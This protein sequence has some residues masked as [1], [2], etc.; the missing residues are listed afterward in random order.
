MYDV[1][2]IG[3]GIVGL[4]TARETLLR[5]PSLTLAVLEKEN[6]IGQHQ[7]GHNSG[8]I[9]SGL[10][11]APGS[12]KAKTCVAGRRALIHYCDAKGIPYD[13]CGKLV[14]ATT[15]KELAGLHM[16]YERGTANGVQDLSLLEPDQFRDIE[17]HVRG[18]RGLYS[19]HTGI[20]DYGQV[21]RAY[22]HDV[23]E[24]GGAILTGHGVE[25][26][27]RRKDGIT[28]ITTAGEIHTRYLVACAGLYA[29]RVARMSI[30][31]RDPQIVPFRGDYYI[32]KPQK[33]HLV[34][35]LI[36][37]VPDPTLP[38]LGVHLTRRM[39]GTVWLGPNAVLAFAREGYR[40]STLSGLDMADTVA[41]PAF[42]KFLRRYWRIGIS[43]LY[44]GLS[45]TAFLASLQQ[46]VPELTA[47]DIE[48]GP[49]GVRA[50]TLSADGQLTDD[51]I[52]SERSH[53]IHV[54]NAPSPAA[55]SSLAIASMIVDR[56]DEHF[57][58]ST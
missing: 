47:D 4:A 58:W 26:I 41:Y 30:L 29:D 56:A 27:D 44:R 50:Q 9:H 14:V 25:D 46:Y 16:L 34:R 40:V 42:W 55:T 8:V 17:P 32:L 15:P 49:A 5:H 24:A 22:A 36:Y 20:V 7:T 37:P 12:V 45:K 57:E 6:A 19:P 18:I 2:V 52:L 54:R 53:E 13:L 35:A 43:E 3:A 39:D 1:V 10:Y 51:F 23:T 33:A 28:V 38:F 48:P 31:P 11:Y 21:A